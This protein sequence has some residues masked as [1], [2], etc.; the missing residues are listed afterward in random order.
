MEPPLNKLTIFRERIQSA[1]NFFDIF[2]EQFEPLSL[3]TPPD[4][5]KCFVP[6][7]SYPKNL[8]QK[9]NLSLS[10]IFSLLNHCP[11]SATAKILRKIINKHF[12]NENHSKSPKQSILKFC[13]EFL[14]DMSELYDLPFLETL[15]FDD[16]E[17]NLR[18]KSMTEE[19]L[20]NYMDKIYLIDHTSAETLEISDIEF[21]L[22]F[23]AE[24]FLLNFT[25][26]L[27]FLLTNLMFFLCGFNESILKK[28]YMGNR[29]DPEFSLVE[30]LCCRDFNLLKDFALEFIQN[31][32]SL[33]YN[34]EI[35]GKWH[36]DFLKI[37]SNVYFQEEFARILFNSKLNIGF[38]KINIILGIDLMIS[39]KVF[40]FESDNN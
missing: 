18:Y 1:L 34:E 38:E 29:E 21:V 8:I 10:L 33:Y 7:I 24:H 2:N 35:F 20:Q 14:T 31:Q 17:E 6:L 16:F 27:T 39:V 32:G 15:R 4:L 11:Q 28:I 3:E 36:G 9:S 30:L 12:L 19:S 23:F 25:L 26:A 40:N 22:S 5:S 13:F 37:A